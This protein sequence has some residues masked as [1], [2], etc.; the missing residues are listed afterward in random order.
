MLDSTWWTMFNDSVLDT[1][2]GL[3]YH[4][5]LPLQ[6]AA[7]RIM[8]SRAQI[9]LAVGRQFPQTQIVVG[10]V[11]VVGVSRNIADAIGI[12]RNF[13]N[14]QIGFDVSWEADFW[15]KYRSGVQ[16]QKADYQSKI[17]IYDNALVS[18]TA[19]VAQTYTMIRTFEALIS[20][21]KQN[22]ILQEEGLKIAQSRFSN[23]AASELDVTQATTLFESTCATIPQLET[24]L[25]Q[26]RN[27]LSTLLGQQSGTVDTLLMHTKGIPVPPLK[28]PVLIPAELIKRR[29][30]IRSAELLAK[31]QSSKIG[32]SKSELYPRF[33]L[34]GMIGTQSSS[35]T[36]VTTDN[37]FGSGSFIYRAGPQVV[38]PVLNYGQLSNDVRVQDAR[39]QQLLFD[40]ENT[41]IKAVQE[42]NDNIT[43]Y[44]KSSETAVFDQNAVKG[45]QRSVQLALTQYREGAVDFQRVLDAQRSLLQEENALV[46]TQSSIATNLI[47][48]YKAL[49]GGWELR[50]GKPIIADST[51]SEMQKRTNWGNLLSKPLQS[52]NTDS[53]E[54]NTGY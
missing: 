10:N 52:E 35:G 8:E 13:V 30:D 49:G 14:Y 40:Y 9:A 50:N 21:A 17:A 43:G 25:I 29:P 46:Y 41:V 22:A 5:N 23:G 47:S 32:I 11:M 53:F 1:L 16:A 18:L 45:A 37:L 4:Q 44:I 26:S 51:R 20:Q 27:A 42:V 6:I 38:W 34:S 12:N 7:M 31:A 54:P 36:G 48:I 15:G 24:S 28:V 3:A 19:S 39:L 2:V 33:S